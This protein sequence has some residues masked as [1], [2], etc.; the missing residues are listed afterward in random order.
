MSQFQGWITQIPPM[1][2]SVKVKGKKLY[3]YARNG[4]TVE[5]PE[6][7]VEIKSIQRVSEIHFKQG[8]C[9][10]DIDITCGKGTYIRTLATDIGKALGFP[11][12]MSRLTRTSSGGFNISDSLTIEQIK[13]LHEQEQLQEKLFPIEYGLKGLPS[14]EIYNEDIK[15]RILN[16]QSFRSLCFLQLFNNKL[17]LLMVGHNKF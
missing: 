8:M 5:R 1:Y 7:K 10:F 11:A 17:Y 3:E 4:E 16:G 12:H 2:S 6:R 14:I 13:V 15:H 9:L